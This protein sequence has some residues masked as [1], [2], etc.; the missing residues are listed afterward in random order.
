MELKD[1]LGRESKSLSTTIIKEKAFY[2]TT[3]FFFGS[4]LAIATALLLIVQRFVKRRLDLLEKKHRE[5]RERETVMNELHMA[6]QIQTSVLPHEFPPFPERNEFELFAS[7]DP[8]REVGGDFYDFFM[9]DDDHLCLV[10]A[11][12]SGKGIPAALFMMNVKLMLKS[13]AQGGVAPS[14]ALEWANKEIC[15]NNQ[16]EMFVTVWLGILEI[17]SGKLVAAN[18]GH[19]YPVIGHPDTGFEL[20]KDKHGLVIGGM[21]GMEYQDYELQLAPGDRLFVYTDGVPEATNSK[22]EMFGTDRMLDA[23][24]AGRDVSPEEMLENVY[25]AVGEFVGEAEKFDDLT[26][27]GMAYH[28]PQEK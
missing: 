18:A 22:N 2:E 28:G 24:N 16:A 8:A 10:I 23:L 26:M 25:K 9:I 17:S 15:E 27:L 13:Y 21:E 5:E 3:A 14:E 11:D 12:V 1:A 20:V 19:E 4:I 6:N 7:M